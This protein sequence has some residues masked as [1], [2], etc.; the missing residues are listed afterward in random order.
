MFHYAA[1]IQTL[2]IVALV[3]CGGGGASTAPAASTASSGDSPPVS[4]TPLVVATPPTVG[5]PPVVGVPSSTVIKSAIELPNTK[6]KLSS[7]IGVTSGFNWTLVSGAGD[8]SIESPNAATT[9]ISL[10][11][12]GIYRFKFSGQ[13]ASGQHIEQINEVS[14]KANKWTANANTTAP[15]FLSQSIKPVYKNGHTLPP[16]GSSSITSHPALL[17]E[18]ADRWGWALQTNVNPEGC[19]PNPSNA[20]NIAGFEYCGGHNDEILKLAVE[21]GGKRRLMLGT[22]LVLPKGDGKLYATP[23]LDINDQPVPRGVV[24]ATRNFTT[25][26]SVWY[27]DG[28]GNGIKSRLGDSGFPDAI[29]EGNPRFS[30]LAPAD[31]VRGRVQEQASCI[32]KFADVYPVSLIADYAEY[33]VRL[34]GADYCLAL[35]D[36]ALLAAVGYPGQP[37]PSCFK[38]IAGKT[39]SRIDDRDAKLARLLGKQ[40]IRNYQITRQEFDTATLAGKKSGGKPALFNV[41]GDSYGYDRGRWGG[42]PNYYSWLEDLNSEKVSFASG[43][44]HYYKDQNSGFEGLSE[45]AQ[46]APTD[47][48]FKA[49][50]N[51]G[52]SILNGEKNLYPWLS[53]GYKDGPD[54]IA[55][56]TLWMGFTKMLFVGGALGGLPGYFNYTKAYQD[57]Q[58]R[59]AP[60][61][62]AVPDWFWPIVDFSHVQALFSHLEAYL[63]EGDLVQGA[64]SYGAKEHPYAA[65]TRPVKFYALQ[66]KGVEY[67]RATCFGELETGTRNYAPTAYVMARKLPGQEKYIFGAWANVGA[68]RE[69]TAIVPG[70]GEV[71][72]QARASGSVYLAERSANGMWSTKL[73]DPNGMLPSA[74]LFD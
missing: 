33:G 47:I 46:C 21:S 12:P 26:E 74:Y 54:Q 65:D 58:T 11:T 40:S 3:G 34:F 67:K 41:Y 62:M 37:D 27:N 13:N 73:L 56:R 5:S 29:G 72:L 66:L 53:A 61:G 51:I 71:R 18:L 25:P 59:N 8:V 42:W 16:I 69:V 45:Q 30:P 70:K 43:I 35:N 64:T 55:D 60:I 32:Q 44:E 23:G 31:W 4:S 28:K 22:A 15:E 10:L 9:R 48:M 52:G 49:L 2:I 6:A 24:A 63:R 20:C 38:T 1:L 14:L 50:N 36:P 39:E 68:D 7:V 17:K 19:N 57:Q